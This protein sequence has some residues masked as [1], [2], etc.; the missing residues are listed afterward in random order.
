MLWVLCCATVLVYLPSLTGGWV[1]DDHDLIEHNAALQNWSPFSTGNLFGPAGMEGHVYRPLVALSFAIEQTLIPGPFLSRVLNLVLLL[2]ATLGLARWARALGASVPMAC[3]GAAVFA[4]HP[5]VSE[6]VAW[7]S[8]RQALLPTTLMICAGAAFFEGKDRTAGV[9]LLLAPFAKEAY[10]LAPLVAGIWCW[11]TNRWSRDLLSLASFGTIAYLVIRT[12]LHIPL[13]PDAGAMEPLAALGGLGLRFGELLIRPDHADPLPILRA[14]G[15]IGASLIV[16]A[17]GALI[18]KRT[19]AAWA[20]VFSL[21]L[22]CVPG[23]LAASHTLLAND[24]YLLSAFAA[25]GLA[26][27]TGAHLLQRPRISSRGTWLVGGAI[28]ATFAVLTTF[29]STAWRSDLA[30]FQTAYDLAPTNPRAA[31]HLGH[32]LH[33]YEGRCDL[34]IPL[35]QLGKDGD[36]RALNNLLACAVDTEDH[37]LALSI[38]EEA[39]RSDTDNP[40]PAAS[41]ARAAAAT[42]DLAG[43]KRWAEEALARGPERARNWVLLGNITGQLGEFSEAV[44]AFE[45]ALALDPTERAAIRGREA[46]QRHLLSERAAPSPDQSESVSDAA[47]TH[48]VSPE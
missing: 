29:R 13:L 43:A 19:R 6:T 39:V 24:R 42:G 20:P 36:S 41:A 37:V 21:A 47:P 17:G 38:A 12:A 10:V 46:A 5:G 44:A 28:C 18:W 22:L 3:F 27:A 40:H 7:V 15:V 8:G 30:L 2:L 23:A 11:S 34:A 25:L 26:L 14:S 31:F 45:R 33:Q 35:Y 4:L 1:W 9:L 16:I 32:A 48:S